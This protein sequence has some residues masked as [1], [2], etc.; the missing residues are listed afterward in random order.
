MS[1][2]TTHASDNPTQYHTITLNAQ[3]QHFSKLP[4]YLK[5]MID[6]VIAPITDQGYL[7]GD[8]SIESDDDSASKGE[9]ISEVVI[10][11]RRAADMS[12]QGQQM[13]YLP[14]DEHITAALQQ[15][16][17]QRAKKSKRKNPEAALEDARVRLMSGSVN[18]IPI[19]LPEI[20]VSC[21]S[22]QSQNHAQSEQQFLGHIEKLLVSAN[23]VVIDGKQYLL[24]D[25]FFELL[26]LAKLKNVEVDDKNYEPEMAMLTTETQRELA[27][28]L[29]DALEK[30]IHIADDA[31]SGGEKSHTERSF[32]I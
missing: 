31:L 23:K 28:A 4:K 5:M 27:V 15:G 14:P 20:D 25:R 24:Y 8:I 26:S 32:M 10:Q 1:A 11:V 7:V 6:E 13:E 2:Q 17:T 30:F 12:A 21:N 22:E 16:L 18:G 29:C 3:S 9:V 19:E